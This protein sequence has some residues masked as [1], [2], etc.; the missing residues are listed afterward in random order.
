[1]NALARIRYEKDM[2]YIELSQKSGVH[3][4]VIRKLEKGNKITTAHYNTKLRLAT[5][6]GVTVRELVTGER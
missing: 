6:L 5:A 4:G 3:A 2:S 1:M